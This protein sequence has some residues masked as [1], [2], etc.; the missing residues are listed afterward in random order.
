MKKMIIGIMVIM[1]CCSFLLCLTGCDNDNYDPCGT[2]Y[3]HY[4]CG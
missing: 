4:D 2:D 3:V 1:L